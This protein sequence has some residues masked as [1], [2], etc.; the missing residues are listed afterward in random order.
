MLGVGDVA[1]FESVARPAIA[2]WGD[3]GPGIPATLDDTFPD[4]DEEEDED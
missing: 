3:A 4:D 2:D 1:W